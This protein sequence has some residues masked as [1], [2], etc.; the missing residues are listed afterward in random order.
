MKRL[1]DKSWGKKKE[2]YAHQTGFSTK[3]RPKKKEE[4][5]ENQKTGWGMRKNSLG[6]GKSGK[7]K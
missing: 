7:K 4:E 5:C 6:E 2:T 3:E 1:G